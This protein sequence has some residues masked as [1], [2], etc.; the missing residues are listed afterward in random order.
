VSRLL[1][2]SDTHFG[3]E[4]PG[5]LVALE[6]LVHC[7][8]PEVLVL[9][10]D[11]TQRATPVQFAT[12]R[13]WLDRLPARHR[14]VVAGNHD[15]PLFDLHERLRHPY[16]RLSAAF[17]PEREPALDLPDWRVL[18]LDT[19][20]WWRHRN[21]TL[22]REQIARTA[23]ALQ[24]ASPGQIRV[25]VT[26]H[27][28]HVTRPEDEVHRP[29]HHRE[30][31]STWAGAGADVLLSGHIHLPVVVPVDTDPPHGQPRPGPAARRLW[32]VQAGT[33]VSR[34]IRENI[35]NTVMLLEALSDERHGRLCGCEIWQCAPEGGEFVRVVS[36][37]LALSPLP[38]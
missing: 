19:T 23:N 28:L 12:A 21:G 24:T 22:S 35:P 31:L 11:I 4:L 10:G 14:V 26:H 13:A 5:V 15:L 36:Q 16:R 7:V 30:A 33:A 34:R 2:L 8:Q 32:S 6:R 17:G 9:S 29:T 1:H 38:A 25:V 27:P 37:R 3:T 18:S 20:R